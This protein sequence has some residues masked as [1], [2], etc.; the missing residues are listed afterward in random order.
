MQK[1]GQRF[2]RFGP[3]CRASADQL[4]GEVIFGCRG[5]RFDQGTDVDLFSFAF[6][7]QFYGER[8]N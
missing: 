1:G 3:G 2:G 7:D 8:L 5:Y 6:S 4:D